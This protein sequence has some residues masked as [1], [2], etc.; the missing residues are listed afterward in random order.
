MM[1]LAESGEMYLESIL[2]LSRTLP[3]IRAIDICEYMNYSKPSISRA[4]GI[5]K[6]GGMITVDDDEGI[7]LTD[8]GLV[9]AEKI[10]ERHN[11]ITDVLVQLGVDQKTAS[12]DAC[13]IE[14]VISEKS[15]AAIKNHAKDIKKHP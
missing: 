6:D 5:L 14:H 15:F 2:V 11:I 4:V 13:R 7:K 3:K 8:A 10:F 9:I 1:N 12:Y